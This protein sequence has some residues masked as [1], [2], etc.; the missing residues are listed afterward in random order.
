VLSE[1]E[2]QP[3]CT[4]L[5]WHPWYS[6]CRRAPPPTS[7]DHV[8]LAL[9]PRLQ[10]M[11]SHR[12]GPAPPGGRRA[13][14][15]RRV[16]GATGAPPRR[17]PPTGPQPPSAV[18]PWGEPT[19]AS[20]DS[21]RVR[22]APASTSAPSGTPAG[23]TAWGR[24]L[25]T[26]SVWQPRGAASKPAGRRP[27]GQGAL[28]APRVTAAAAVA[29]AARPAVLCRQCID[30][31]PC[32]SRGVLP[33]HF[34]MRRSALATNRLLPLPCGRATCVQTTLCMLWLAFSPGGTGVAAGWWVRAAHPPGV[35]TNPGRSAAPPPGV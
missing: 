32:L 12:I 5:A 4:G 20:L 22:L 24:P 10:S 1:S 15:Q 16:P 14:L 28:A 6:S 17:Q 26:P 18:R 30:K 11:R 31:L 25:A 35:W 19:P 27:P 2:S 8:A 29:T 9:T 33:L 13:P 34:A 3:C 7:L 21:R 23:L